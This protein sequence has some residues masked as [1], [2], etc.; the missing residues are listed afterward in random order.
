MSA[1]QPSEAARRPIRVTLKVFGGLRDLRPSPIET[2]TVPAGCTVAD[3]WDR[4]QGEDPRFA[5]A[6]REGVASGYLH[7]LVNGRNIVFLDGPRTRLS[8]GDT[9]AVLPPIGGG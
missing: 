2:R 6:L 3:L 1:N 4:L 9:V 8:N 7:V 5:T